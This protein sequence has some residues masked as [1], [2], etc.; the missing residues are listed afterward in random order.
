MYYDQELIIIV[1]FGMLT[2][3]TTDIDKSVSDKQ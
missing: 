3:I 2:K 1:Y